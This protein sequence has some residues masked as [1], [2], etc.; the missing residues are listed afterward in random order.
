MKV[1]YGELKGQVLRGASAVRA[2]AHRFGAAQ[3]T[4]GH[5]NTTVAAEHMRWVRAPAD[6]D[7]S[8]MERALSWESFNAPVEKCAVE[9]AV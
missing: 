5:A 7:G 4:R 9:K 2:E 6:P 8:G 1:L 3:H